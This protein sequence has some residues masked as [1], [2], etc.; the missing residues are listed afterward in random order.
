MSEDARFQGGPG[1][2]GFDGSL[3]EIGPLRVNPDGTLREVKNTAWN[4]YANVLFCES[5]S[6]WREGGG[7]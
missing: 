1:C 3:V 5:P 4:E 7:S 2:S 6:C